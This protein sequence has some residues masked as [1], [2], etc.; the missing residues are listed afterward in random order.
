MF[1]F[2]SFHCTTHTCTLKYLWNLEEMLHVWIENNSVLDI[3]SLFN[4][5]FLVSWN[6]SCLCM[7][8]NI[9][10]QHFSLCSLTLRPLHHLSTWSWPPSLPTVSSWLWSSTFPERI[11]PPWQRDWWGQNLFSHPWHID[12]LWAR[13]LWE[14]DTKQTRMKNNED[15]VVFVT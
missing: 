9:F 15:Q 14:I 10:Y 11:R 6:R 3:L 7:M 13:S 1:F 5:I 12:G 2:P 4:V 8:Y